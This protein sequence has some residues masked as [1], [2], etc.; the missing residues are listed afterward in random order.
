MSPLNGKKHLSPITFRL[1]QPML[2]TFFSVNLHLPKA[3]KFAHIHLLLG[4]FYHFPQ[5]LTFVFPEFAPLTHI[6][7]S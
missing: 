3:T 4:R 7:P 2:A 6:H 5:H 1:I